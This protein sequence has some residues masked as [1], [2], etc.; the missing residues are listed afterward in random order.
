M[1]GLHTACRWHALDTRWCRSINH[2]PAALLTKYKGPEMEKPVIR[3]YT[4]VSHEGIPALAVLYLIQIAYET[5]S[6]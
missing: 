5:F 3:P 6:P 2:Y 4:P 1:S